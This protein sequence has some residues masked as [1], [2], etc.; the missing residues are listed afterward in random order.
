MGSLFAH[1]DVLEQQHISR[2]TLRRCRLCMRG[3]SPYDRTYD[4]SIEEHGT[5]ERKQCL[6]VQRICFYRP[7]PRKQQASLANE[8][9][10][11]SGRCVQLGKHSS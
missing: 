4:T 8:R 3:Y 5:A 1:T 9:L 11:S 10:R 7:G 2:W 6:G